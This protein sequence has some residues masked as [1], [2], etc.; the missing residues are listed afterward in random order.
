[1]TETLELPTTIMVLSVPQQQQRRRRRDSHIILPVLKNHIKKTSFHAL[2]ILYY[3]LPMDCVAVLTGAQ[4]VGGGTPRTT[5]V[6]SVPKNRRRL[7]HPSYLPSRPRI[8]P[9]LLTFLV[10][11]RKIKTRLLPMYPWP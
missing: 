1:M 7:V 8:H 10:L 9:V 11:R 6:S 5:T 3:C 4:V 2:V